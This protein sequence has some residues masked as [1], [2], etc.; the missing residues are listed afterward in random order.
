MSL[1]NS[2][3]GSCRAVES[4]TPS[5]SRRRYERAE[6]RRLEWAMILRAAEA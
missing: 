4:L 5:N 6:Q 3:E 1:R 2:D